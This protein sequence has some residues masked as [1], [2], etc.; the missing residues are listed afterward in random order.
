LLSYRHS[1]HSGNFADILKHIVVVEILEHLIKKEK[2]FEYIDTHSG[3]GLFD[4]KSEHAQKLCEHADGIGK[5]KANDPPGLSRYFGVIDG[6]NPSGSLDFYPGSP[7]IAKHFLRPHDR[8]WLY[9]L[10]PQ[11]FKLLCENIGKDRRIKTFCQ[12][13]LKELDS[14][15]PP[16]SRRGFVLIDPSY[17]IKSE[18]DQVFYAI[19]KA[20]KKFA[21]GIYA[22]WY[23][24]VDR[25]KIDLLEKRFTL[26]NIKNIQQFELGV[27]PDSH[28][29]GMTSAGMFVINPPW[30]LF[31]KMSDM[32]PKMARIIGDDNGNFFKCN[33]LSNE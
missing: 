10:H 6:Y 1:F 33:I 30:T 4:L 26:S 28:E 23:P 19:E 11:D 8:A 18:Y 7:L 24:V 22:V 32:L 13:G 15:L 17:E 2:P 25:G 3:A 16:T 14:L 20:Y 9:E 31:D 12:D 27:A 21:T 29:R 5:L